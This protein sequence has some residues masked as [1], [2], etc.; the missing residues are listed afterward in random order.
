[1]PGQSGTYRH[2]R[3]RVTG[4]FADSGQIARFFDGL[5]MVEPGLVRVPQWRPASELEAR[6]PA[7]L[8]GGVG[9]KN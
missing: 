8:W 2:L 7:G 5:E 3:A 1:M 6:S 9:R 4:L